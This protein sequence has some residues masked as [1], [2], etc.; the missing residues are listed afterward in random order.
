MDSINFVVIE[1]EEVR[2]IV[3]TEKVGP[4]SVFHDISLAYNKIWRM[5]KKTYMHFEEES[6]S[7]I[8]PKFQLDTCMFV[9]V[10]C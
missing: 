4:G 9:A 2:D 8:C 1:N 5:K 3:K 7:Y 6:I 10:F